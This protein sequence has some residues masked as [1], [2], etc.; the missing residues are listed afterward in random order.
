MAVLLFLSTAAVIV[1]AGTNL[2]RY[3]DVIAER[4]GLGRTFV[5]LVLTASITS[6]PELVTGLSS[7]A[8]HDAPE[9]AVG[10]VAGSL[11]F[12]LL[13]LVLVDALAPAGTPAPDFRSG[14]PLLLGGAALGTL[15]AAAGLAWPRALPGLGRVGAATPVLAVLYFVV[16]RRVYLRN[17]PPEAPAPEPDGMPLRKAAGLYA[18]NA[19]LVVAAA[20]FLPKLAVDLA[21]HTGLGQSFVGAALVG[22]T[23]SLPELAV[24]VAAVRLKAVDLAVAGLLGSNL[25]DLLVLA[26]DDVAYA[27]GPLLGAVSADHLVPLLTALGMSGVLAVAVGLRAWPGRTRRFSAASVLLAAL[28]AA[29][30]VVMYVRRPTG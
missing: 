17:R 9:V 6:L 19:A 28:Y 21:D 2:S 3:G 18:A 13:L 20:G 30:L 15:V 1:L 11:V 24:T 8:L 14:H 5:G 29:H 10:D 26:V 22:A 16:L 23:T 27:P 7:V 4:S 25:F 12:N